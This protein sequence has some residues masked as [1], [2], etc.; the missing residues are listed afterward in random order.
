MVTVGVRQ[1][2][3]MKTIWKKLIERIFPGT[4]DEYLE[5]KEIHKAEIKVYRKKPQFIVGFILYGA[6]CVYLLRQKEWSLMICVLVIA[7]GEMLLRD[8]ISEHY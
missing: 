4:Y 2:K 1:M 7:I 5:S 6:P 8:T 3:N